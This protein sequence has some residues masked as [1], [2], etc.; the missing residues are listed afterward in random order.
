MTAEVLKYTREQIEALELAPGSEHEKLEGWV[1]DARQRRRPARALSK[2]PSII[3]ATSRSRSNPARKSK[4]TSSIA[5]PAPRWP[6]PGCS[7]SRPTRPTSARSA[8]PKSPASNS[9]AK[10]A[11]PAST[12]KTGSKLE[13]E[14]SRRRKEHRPPSRSAGVIRS[15]NPHPGLC[16]G[17]LSAGNASFLHYLRQA[18]VKLLTLSRCRWR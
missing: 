9:A 13:R 5:T 3:A 8:T 15:L 2:R 12:G 10:I 16:L 14:E 17:K 4:P 7:T 6:S 1:P 18:E 11:P